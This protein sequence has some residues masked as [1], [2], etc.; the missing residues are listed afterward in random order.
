[1]QVSI[2][3]KGKGLVTEEEVHSMGVRG[4][5]T[6]TYNRYIVFRVDELVVHG[7]CS[8]PNVVLFC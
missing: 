6:T 2:L 8:L 5:Y 4:R 7:R 3:A 1:M